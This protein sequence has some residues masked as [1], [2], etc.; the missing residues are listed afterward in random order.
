M[1]IIRSH[2]SQTIISGIHLSFQGWGSWKLYNGQRFQGHS[3]TSNLRPF[4][5]IVNSWV[6]NIL[7]LKNMLFLWLPNGHGSLIMISSI[8]RWTTHESV[9]PAWNYI[10]IY[11]SYDLQM[12]QKKSK[13]TCTVMP[14]LAKMPLSAEVKLS[15]D[16]QCSA[17]WQAVKMSDSLDLKI[18]WRCT[19]ACAQKQRNIRKLRV[20]NQ[21]S[22]S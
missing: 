8:Q 1:F 2:L 6:Y 14:A 15:L 13:H 4:K 3:K 19:V 12:H 11:E 18:G 7:V 16:F 5:M 17:T 9:C 21:L 22:S 10:Y 20:M